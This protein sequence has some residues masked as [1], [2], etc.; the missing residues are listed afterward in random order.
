MTNRVRLNIFRN[1]FRTKWVYRKFT[2]YQPECK[3]GTKDV[4]TSIKKDYL[5]KLTGS[6]Q[7]IEGA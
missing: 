5:I 4:K 6:T 1:R 2:E 7:H 3:F